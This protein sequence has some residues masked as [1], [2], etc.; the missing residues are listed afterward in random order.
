MKHVECYIVTSKTGMVVFLDYQDAML[1]C[2]NDASAFITK[3]TIHT[4]KP[5][6]KK[7]PN[8]Q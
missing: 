7:K 5:Q 4:P 8:E 1:A 6:P 3:S 2:A